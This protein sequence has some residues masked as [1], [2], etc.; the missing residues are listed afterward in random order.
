MT[1]NFKTVT[2]TLTFVAIARI[3]TRNGTV[4][5]KEAN[6]AFCTIR[7]IMFNKVYFM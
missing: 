4:D 2:L 1:V 6:I 5:T 3:S 7:Y